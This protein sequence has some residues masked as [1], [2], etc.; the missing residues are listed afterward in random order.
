MDLDIQNT[1]PEEDGLFYSETEKD[2]ENACIGHLR[3]DFGSCGEEFW[4]SWWEHQN[5]L[6]AQAFRD[7][8][9]ELVNSLREQGL[10]KSRNDMATYC[11]QHPE[12]EISSAWQRDSYGF[13]IETEKHRY[14]IRCA[15]CPGDY[16]FYI[17]CYSKEPERDQEQPGGETRAAPPKHRKS[18][19]P[20]R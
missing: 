12:A 14:Y 16:N 8:F 4:T 17:Y 15:P 3:G 6:K 19:E 20:E 5:N 11:A 7:E 18:S 9:D 1:R 2:R 13:R 10:L